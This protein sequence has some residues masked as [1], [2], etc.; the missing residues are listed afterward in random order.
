MQRFS[1]LSAIFH[2]LYSA[3]LYRDVATRW[4]GLGLS[5]LLLFTFLLIT[6]AQLIGQYMLDRA[7]FELQPGLLNPTEKLIEDIANQIPKMEYRFKKL[8]VIDQEAHIIYLNEEEKK[9]PLVLIDHNVKPETFTD[10]TPP[11]IVA[12]AA[13]YI[14]KPGGEMRTIT[15]EELKLEEQY[16]DPHVFAGWAALGL[17]WLHEKRMILHVTFGLFLWSLLMLMV[18]L[19]R[20]MQAFAFGLIGYVIALLMQMKTPYFVCV[21]LAA[22]AITPMILADVA[23]GIALSDSMSSALF[24]ILTTGYMAYALHANR[25]DD[26]DAELPA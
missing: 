19:W 17:K 12:E 2:S 23:I 9:T 16:L 13:I 20:A 14:R 10:A 5:Y 18:F 7:M 11:I 4:E 26:A 3:N 6:P 25:P 1:K 21:R 24:V 15:Y 8:R 22:V